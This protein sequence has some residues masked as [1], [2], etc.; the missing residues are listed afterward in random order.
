MYN[1]YNFIY[2]IGNNVHNPINFSS[3]HD[4]VKLIFRFHERNFN[5]VRSHNIFASNVCISI[6]A[7]QN[8]YKPPA[9]SILY[10]YF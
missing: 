2:Y 7:V 8:Q 5:F 3:L 10:G 4:D 1:I 6:G 9:S